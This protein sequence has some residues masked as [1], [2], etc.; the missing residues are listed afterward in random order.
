MNV[1]DFD[2]A[3]VNEPKVGLLAISEKFRFATLSICNG[4]IRV[5]PILVL[6]LADLD[7]L[8]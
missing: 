8:D 4:L 6:D 1:D 2:D 3:H 7:K 5:F